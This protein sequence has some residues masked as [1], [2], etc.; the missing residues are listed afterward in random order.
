MAPGPRTYSPGEDD[1]SQIWRLGRLEKQLD[2]IKAEVDRRHLDNRDTLA[3]IEKQLAVQERELAATCKTLDNLLKAAWALIT[4]IIIAVLGALLKLVISPGGASLPKTAIIEPPA[5]ESH[6][7]PP[8]VADGS[9]EA[10]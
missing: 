1:Q 2:E 3:R 8:D 6:M 4:V 10:P 5:L 7:A 9:A